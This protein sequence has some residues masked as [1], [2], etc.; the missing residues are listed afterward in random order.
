M[1]FKPRWRKRGREREGER[2]REREREG[3]RGR[4]RE[5]KKR[6]RKKTFSNNGSFL[7]AFPSFLCLP[8]LKKALEFDGEITKKLKKKVQLI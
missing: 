8:F 5:R 6:E 3:E 4:E 2:G 1:F 7:F